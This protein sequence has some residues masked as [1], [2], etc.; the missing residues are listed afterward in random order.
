M[1]AQVTRHL[2]E[3]T[4]AVGGTFRPGDVQVSPRSGGT[5]HLPWEGCALPEFMEWQTMSRVGQVVHLRF[6]KGFPGGAGSVLGASAPVCPSPA[7][8]GAESHG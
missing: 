5:G 7:A 2:T 8:R 3:E 1:Q 4:G 6:W